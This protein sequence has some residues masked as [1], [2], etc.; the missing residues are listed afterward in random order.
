[1]KKETKRLLTILLITSLLLILIAGSIFYY[2]IFGPQFHPPKTSYVYIDR[3]DTTDSIFYKV[4]QK[5][6]ANNLTGFRWMAHYKKLEQNIHTGRYAIRPGDNVYYVYSRISRGYQDPMNLTIVPTRTLTA[7]S[8]NV[9]RQLMIDS[10]EI[11]HSLTDTLFLQQM[12]FDKSNIY[13]LFLPDTYQVYWDMSPND[14]LQRMKEEYN[15]FWNKARLD[16]AT[17]IGMTPKEV[18][19]LASIIDEE[20]NNAQEKPIIAGIYINRLQRGMYLQACP[21]IKFALQDFTLQ[22]ITDAHLRIKSPY[23]TYTHLGLPPGPIRIPSK[24]A[25]ESVL[26]Y[27]H[28]NYLYMCAKEDFSGTHNFA[29]NYTDHMRNARKYWKALNERKIFK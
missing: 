14:F 18:T 12:G 25:I 15:R 17:S 28:H 9:G 8:R 7:L 27:T 26:N 23:N 19:T 20:T 10:I 4:E 3:D 11:A 2:F 1:M 22:R 24:E 29:S 16:K 13:S 21:T 6:H 5:G